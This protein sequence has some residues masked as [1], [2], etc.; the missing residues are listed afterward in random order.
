[1]ISIYAD[2]SSSGGSSRPGGYGWIIC[3]GPD[4]LG[5]GY[6]GSVATTNNLMEAEGAIQGMINA[7]SLGL[8]GSETTEL[9][10]DSQYVLG[11]AS[12]GYSP[13]KNLE[14]AKQLRAL[15]V[16]LG[17]RFRWVRGHTGDIFNEKCDILAKQGKVENTPEADRKVNHRK[18]RKARRKALPLIP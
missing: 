2:G 10:C 3:R 11:L 12:G 18:A 16:E 1:M 15:A 6:G 9:V 13:T 17:C 5:W 14:M 8:H 7:L 4:V